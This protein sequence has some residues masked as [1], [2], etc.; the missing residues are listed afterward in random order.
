ML[1]GTI[2]SKIYDCFIG[3]M[4]SLYGIGVATAP[5]IVRWPTFSHLIIYHISYIRKFELGEMEIDT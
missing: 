1:R 5:E 2:S 4:D 3:W